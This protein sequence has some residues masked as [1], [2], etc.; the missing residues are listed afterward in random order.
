[1]I[2][3]VSAR[4]TLGALALA[5][6]ILATAG[7]A[8]ANCLDPAAEDAL[9]VHALRAELMVAALSCGFDDA[10][11]RLISRHRGELARQSRV[12]DEALTD[13]SVPG[14]LEALFT[15]LAN[16]ASW[17]SIT[18][19]LAACTRWDALFQAVDGA[20][21]EGGGPRDTLAALAGETAA[22]GR[23]WQ[24]P[25]SAVLIGVARCTG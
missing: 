18:E 5:A 4:L 25:D 21:R 17:R 3:G 24:G 2:N 6:A 11:N 14:G 16:E 10:Y 7:S 15:R 13:V 9:A 20:G 12:L 22:G 8:R 19:G 23:L 1:M